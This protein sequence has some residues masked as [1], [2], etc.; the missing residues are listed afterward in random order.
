MKFIFLCIFIILSSVLYVSAQCAEGNLSRYEISVKDRTD[1]KVSNATFSLLNYK[2]NKKNTKSI[3]SKETLNGNY[4]F[5]WN[6]SKFETENEYLI[7]SN[8]YLIE[9]SAEGYENS[10][11]TIRFYPCRSQ[12]FEVV[13]RK[14][15]DNSTTVKGIIMDFYGARIPGAE[16]I[17]K[18]ENKEY[19]TI[20]G[21]EGEYKLNLDK[22]SYRLEVKSQGFKTFKIEK[23]NIA[24]KYI[25]TM[26]LDIVLDITG[27]TSCTKNC[28]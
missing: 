6:Q 4:L 14:L 28:L 12:Y 1:N 5:E 20:S 26:N 24:T 22:G 25:D 10:L 13:L 17:A 18:K 16:V 11:E 21:K 9:V 8:F 15:N 27:L 19:K 3:E 23:L 7:N 2:D